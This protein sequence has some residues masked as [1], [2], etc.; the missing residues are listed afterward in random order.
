MFMQMFLNKRDVADV[1]DFN[2]WTSLFRPL[3]V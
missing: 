2:H 1:I 3:F